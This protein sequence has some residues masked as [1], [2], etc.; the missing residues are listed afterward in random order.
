MEYQLDDGEACHAKYPDTFELPA[1]FIRK[2]LCVGDHAKL[3]FIVDDFT[4]RMWVLITSKEDSKYIGT[5]DN[6]PQF[7]ALK[8]GAIITFEPKHIIDFLVANKEKEDAPF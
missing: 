2:N 1:E 4:E 8:Y 3:M 6:Q 5:L 7:S